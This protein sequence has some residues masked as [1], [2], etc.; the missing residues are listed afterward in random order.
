MTDKPK[1]TNDRINP[2]YPFYPRLSED[3]IRDVQALVDDFRKALTKVA[4]EVIGNLYCDIAPHIESDSWTNFRN[5]VMAGFRDYG[6][7]DKAQFDYAEIRA[8]LW[9]DNRDEIAKD[10]ESDIIAENTRLKEQIEMM[11]DR[12]Y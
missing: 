3:G 1:V 6:N 8:K 5:D 2:D 7:K 4:E 9:E 12:R 10:I 11:R